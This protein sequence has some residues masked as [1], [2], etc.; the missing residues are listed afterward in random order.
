M[1]PTTKLWMLLLLACLASPL[2]AQDF[3]LFYAKNVTDATHFSDLALLDKELTWRKLDKNAI[4]GNQDEVNQIKEMLGSTQM[5]GLPELQQFWRMRDHSLLCF[6]INDGS[7]QSGVY[8]VEVNYGYDHNG[9]PLTLSLTTSNYFFT[10]VPL[11]EQ[12]TTVKVWR[13]NDPDNF[14]QLRYWSYDWDND[15]VYIF[16]LDQK[17]QSTGDTYKMEY[18]TTYSDANNEVHPESHVLELKETYFQSFYVPEG[19]TLSEV[20]LMAGNERDGDVKLKLNLK[21]LHA[22]IDI[23][24]KFNIPRL[25]P[26]FEFAKHENR[27][28]MNFNWMG[29]GLFEKYDTLYLK[30]FNE[31]G[32]AMDKATINIHRIDKEGNIT[33]K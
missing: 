1:N 13:A 31:K 18:V 28:L 32:A 10:N 11:Q 22:G 6:R 4:D 25:L 20:Y 24:N 19:H 17:R 14:Y 5:K 21:N 29:T 30:L 15:N 7:G 3:D 2:S 33:L 12:E 9:D 8:H 26:T 23:D 16:Q 27:E